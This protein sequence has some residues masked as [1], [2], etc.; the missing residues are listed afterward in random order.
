[1]TLHLVLPLPKRIYFL[2]E[3]VVYLII[4]D[5]V[6]PVGT[7]PELSLGYILLMLWREQFLL[8]VEHFVERLRGGLCRISVFVARAC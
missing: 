5:G 6:H 2:Q 8:N 3:V 7:S 4:R 1:M